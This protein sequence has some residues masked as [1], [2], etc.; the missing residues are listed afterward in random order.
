MGIYIIRAFFVLLST[1][2]GYYL[3]PESRFSGALV[4]WIGSIAVVGIEILIEKIPMKKLI[5][6]VMGLIVGLIT[7]NLMTNFFLLI[8]IDNPDVKNYM[9]FA[10]YFAF[11]YI[12][13]MF[14]LKGMEEL[15]FF[16][17]AIHGIKNRERLIVI[18]TSVLI[19]GRVYELVKNGFISHA[20]VIPK[21]V[22]KEMHT[23]SDA[24]SD[25]KRQRGR[26]GLD[27]LNKMRHDGKIDVKIYDAD[28]PDIEEVD[29]KLVKL[30]ADLGADILTN[31]F[32]LSKIAEIQ[33]IKVLNMNTLAT[34][35]KPSLM[36]GES[37]SIKIIKE[38]KESGQGVGYL[39]DGTMVVVED[40]SKYTG[41][42]ID[43]VVDSTIQT[44]TGRI[45]F[46]VV[47]GVD[48][49]HDRH[50]SNKRR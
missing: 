49:G 42:V 36:S 33:N 40:A 18:D 41:K 3:V 26:R 2:T 30:A 20:L 25:I 11:S 46:G 22:I 10:L 50:N 13:I 9:R 37:I 6:A 48:K 43:V 23:L 21:F 12:G 44:S 39:E 5:L 8:P 17:P 15:G 19:D 7:A 47:G 31:D 1:L 35:M 27:V 38:G 34:L 32:N 14:G 4:G 24:S 16:F 28:Y 29:T 45:L